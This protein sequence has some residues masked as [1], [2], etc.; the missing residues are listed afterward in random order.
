MINDY[1]YAALKTKIKSAFD[2]LAALSYTNL[3]FAIRVDLNKHIFDTLEDFKTMI[4]E[5]NKS[6]HK[7]T[8]K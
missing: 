4:V 6:F 7:S 1:D 8:E 3:P 5:E 2:C